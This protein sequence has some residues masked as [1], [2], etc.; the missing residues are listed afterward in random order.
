MRELRLIALPEAVR[1][2]TGFNAERMGLH[3]RGRIAANLAA[4]VVVFDAETVGDHWTPGAG[5]RPPTGI[6]TVVLNGRVVVEHGRFDRASRAGV[7]LR[8]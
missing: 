2:M 4:D 5:N 7:V 3:D 1:R 6:E 8:R